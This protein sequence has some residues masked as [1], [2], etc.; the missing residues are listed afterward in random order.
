MV[1]PW[2]LHNRNCIGQSFSLSS[3]CCNTHITTS[4][5]NWGFWGSTYCWKKSCTTKD[6][7]Y[8]IVYRLLYIPGGWEWDFW[9][10]NRSSSCSKFSRKIHHPLRPL[11]LPQYHQGSY[12]SSV[13]QPTHPPI[14]IMGCCSVA[15]GGILIICCFNTLQQQWNHHC[16]QFTAHW[17]TFQSWFCE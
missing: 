16:L 7:D 3:G 8:P 17:R 10:I 4:V 1:K 11:S 5:E 13:H 2:H 6:D 15:I 14:Q 12:F 9:T